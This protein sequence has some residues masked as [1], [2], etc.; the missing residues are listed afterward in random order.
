MRLNISVIN[1]RKQIFVTYFDYLPV[2]FIIS[3]VISMISSG[4]NIWS[5]LELFFFVPGII[6]FYIVSR[7]SLKQ[8][9]DLI[10]ILFL[11]SCILSLYAVYQYFVGIDQTIGY[12]KRIGYSNEVHMS[13]LAKKRVFGTMI[14]PNIFVSYLAMMLFTGLGLAFSS[15]KV[16]KALYLFGVLL[17]TAALIFTKSIGG[18]IAFFVTFILFIVWSLSGSGF[19]QTALKYSG[20]GLIFISVIGFLIF[21]RSRI[22]QFVDLSNQNNS[23]IQR[24]YYWKASF[25]MIKD[26]PFFGVGWRKFG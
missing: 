12:L 18:F 10:K 11:A 22:L 14:S 26:Y 3:M 20:L 17:V 2:L 6:V 19:K 13:A 23:L 4:Y 25:S 1:G 15:T 9:D 24:L 21:S 8:I 5:L 16:K 7:I